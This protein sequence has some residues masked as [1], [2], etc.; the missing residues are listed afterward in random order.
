[1]ST[2]TRAP[3]V[4][5]QILSRGLDP[6]QVGHAYV[7]HDDIGS[8]ALHMASPGVAGA[9]SPITSMSGSASRIIRK[10]VRTRLPLVIPPGR[11]GSRARGFRGDLCVDSEAA[12]R[13]WS[14][15]QA[16]AVQGDAL[17]HAGQA[18]SDGTAHRL[19]ADLRAAVDNV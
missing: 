3:V 8:I 11:P 2:T 7:H 19:M 16:S 18:V 1:M 6:V 10:P 12:F 13:S 14:C 17:T 4:P 9:A 15:V 5:E